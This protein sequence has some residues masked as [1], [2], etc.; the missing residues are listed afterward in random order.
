M[1]FLNYLCIRCGDNRCPGSACKRTLHFSAVLHFCFSES[2]LGG[3]QTLGFS[4][5]QLFEGESGAF[6][7]GSRELEVPMDFQ[8]CAGW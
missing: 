4:D 1:T 6:E 5:H 8:W 3:E 2:G 7:G